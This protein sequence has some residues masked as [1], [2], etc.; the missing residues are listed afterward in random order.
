MLS[1]ASAMVAV[2]TTTVRM[3]RTLAWVCPSRSAVTRDSQAA[4]RRTAALAVMMNATAP[5]AHI[6]RTVTCGECRSPLAAVVAAPAASTVRM[7]GCHPGAGRRGRA[8]VD[9]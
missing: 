5:A 8:L 9:T 7:A 1:M 2:P 4:V 6:S 3:R